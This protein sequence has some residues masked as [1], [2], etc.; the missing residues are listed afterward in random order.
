MRRQQIKTEGI[1]LGSKKI[2][3]NDKFVFIYTRNHGKIKAV[4]KGA[5]KPS[6]KFTGVIETL[7]H[8][9]FD[10]YQSP[11]KLIITEAKI[12]KSFKKIREN[13]PRIV[14]AFVITK[15]ANDL[16]LEHISTPKIFDEMEKA[17]KKIE[18]NKR[19][20]H[21]IMISLSFIVKLLSNLGLLPDFHHREFTTSPHHSSKLEKKYIKLLNFLQKNSFDK[22]DNIHI[23]KTE[24]MAIKNILRD[25][26]ENETEKGLNLPL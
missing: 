23:T 18:K 24:E 11:Q 2:G 5:L 12:E 4:A 20:E 13:L 7:N 14:N 10:L 1:I 17:L 25:I 15:V 6:S 9:K 22:V 3:E 21:L 26:A 16:L 8:C 19:E